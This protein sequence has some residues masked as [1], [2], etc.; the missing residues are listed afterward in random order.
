MNKERRKKT[1]RSKNVGPPS[2]SHTENRE[3]EDDANCPEFVPT[4]HDLLQLVN[5]WV[6]EALDY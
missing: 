6:K 2:E 3:I 1:E 4:R 5:F